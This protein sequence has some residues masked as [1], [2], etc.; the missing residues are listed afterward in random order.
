MIYDSDTKA[1]GTKVM[2]TKVMIGRAPNVQSDTKTSG[3]M[4]WH[5]LYEREKTARLAAEASL[6]A[7]TRDLNQ[8]HQALEQQV[9][10]SVKLLTDVLAMA[11]PEIFEKSG[12]VQRWA[13]Q[14]APD[15]N[16]RRP[17]VLEL[18]ALLHPLGVLSLP[19]DVADRYARGDELSAEEQ[20]HIA[21]S[22]VVAAK[23]LD[24]IPH[25]SAVA[26]A[27]LYSRKGYDGGGYPEDP[28]C[29][30]DLPQ[31]ARI[32]KV[33]IDLADDSTGPNRHRDF[34]DMMARKAQ[35]DLD[36]LKVAFTRLRRAPHEP[37]QPDGEILQLS[38]LNLRSGDIVHRDIMSDE[39]HLLLAAGAE[40]TPLTIKR[41]RSFAQ[42]RS[43][44]M[45]VEV[46]RPDCSDCRN[47]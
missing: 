22:A 1:M 45:S 23:L 8:A 29:G 21:E 40:L 36:I 16:V 46:L 25:M 42:T 15:L 44:P 47:T 35:Y 26:R 41:L 14:I 12:K 11:R 34:N 38:V 33:L 28:I 18:A 5:D 37:I 9:S 30:Q 10:G 39:D 27:I 20:Q 24:N 43:E 17:W 6:E 4:S 32:L 13:R 3:E 19:D 2:D 7:A 31:T